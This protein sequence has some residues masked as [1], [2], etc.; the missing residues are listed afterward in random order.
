MRW[1][2]WY[3][4][5]KRRPDHEF[6]RKWDLPRNG[7]TFTM[8]IKLSTMEYDARL[9]SSGYNSEVV[10]I[11]L[12]FSKCRHYLCYSFAWSLPYLPKHIICMGHNGVG[13]VY[14]RLD[15]FSPSRRPCIQMNHPVQLSNDWLCGLVWTL[16]EVWFNPLLSRRMRHCLEDSTSLDLEDYSPWEDTSVQRAT[17]RWLF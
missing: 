2:A 15:I 3:T 1:A 4:I 10:E 8:A 11:R 14:E 5:S 16:H 17:K 12:Y 7:I 9:T 6:S 13:I